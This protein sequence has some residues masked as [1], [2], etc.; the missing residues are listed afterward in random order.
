MAS[1]VLERLKG[2]DPGGLVLLSE[3]WRKSADTNL[4][5]A[6]SR[7]VWTLLTYD[8]VNDTKVVAEFLSV[9]RMPVSKIPPEQSWQIVERFIHPHT[10]ETV[11]EAALE[12]SLQLIQSGAKPSQ[13]V[14]A[15]L[16]QLQQ[17]CPHSR[18]RTF[19]NQCMVALH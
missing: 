14:Q 5:Q 7:E 3:L 15:Q 10:D 18:I 6:I 11:C 19:V 17:T 13:N 16:A 4:Q 2:N 12:L 1:A 8:E 9:M